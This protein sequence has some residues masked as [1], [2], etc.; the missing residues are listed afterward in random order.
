M[1]FRQFQLMLIRNQL[2]HDVSDRP[3]LLQMR[4]KAQNQ[5]DHPMNVKGFLQ[6]PF[7]ILLIY[8]Q[9]KVYSTASLLP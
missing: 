6:E 9:C 5:K 4:R 2:T 1:D 3:F 8:P 7:Q